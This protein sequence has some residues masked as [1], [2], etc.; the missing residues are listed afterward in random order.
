MKFDLRNKTLSS[1]TNYYIIIFMISTRNYLHNNSQIFCRIIKAFNPFFQ[2]NK[3]QT[4]QNKTNH[5]RRHKVQSNRFQAT[6]KPK[7]LRI[8][9]HSAKGG[10][11]IRKKN[12]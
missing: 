11:I 10:A 7:F 12:S 4:R 2:S 5:K 3:S 6:N 1:I 8:R 9:I